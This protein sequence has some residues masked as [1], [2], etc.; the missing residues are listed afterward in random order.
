MILLQSFP[1]HML[2]TLVTQEEAQFIL[3]RGPSNDLPISYSYLR[4][5]W[6]LKILANQIALPVSLGAVISLLRPCS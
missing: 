3:M 2:V 4:K 6:S 5:K 1:K